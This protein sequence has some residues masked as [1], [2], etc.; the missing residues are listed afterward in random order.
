LEMLYV[1]VGEGRGC[2]GWNRTLCRTGI[3]LWLRIIGTML[4]MR[5][6][7]VFVMLELLDDVSQH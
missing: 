3:L 2:V 5:Q 6:R 4:W 7:V 1:I